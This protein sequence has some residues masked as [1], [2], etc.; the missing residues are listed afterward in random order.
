MKLIKLILL[1][2][3]FCATVT[4][5][6]ATPIDVTSF[7]AVGDNSTDNRVFIQNAINSAAAGDTVYF[8]PGLFNVSGT[9]YVPSNIRVQGTGS[10]VYNTQ[11]RLTPTQTALFEVVENGA[12]N[13][14]FKDLTLVANSNPNVYPRNSASETALIRTEGTTG[15]SFKA[16][17]GGM[18]NIVIENVRTTQ[19][20]YGIAATSATPGS[21]YPITDV[22]IRNYASDGNEYSLYTKTKGAGGWDVQNM[23]VYPMYDGQNGIFLERSGQMQFLQLSCAGVNTANTC[24]K[25]WNNGDTYFRQMHVE[26][27]RLGFCVGTNCIPNQSETPVENASRITVENSATGGEIN[28]A[29][30][31]VTINNRFWLDY[32]TNPPPSPYRFFGTGTNSTLTSCG[33]VW[34]SWN[35]STHRTNTTV[36]IPSWA[37]P[38]LTN[39]VSGCVN[40]YLTPVPI[41]KTGYEADN[42]RL[43]GEIDVTA[44]PFYA[45]PNDGLD[46]TTAFVNAI[47]AAN[48][49]RGKRVFVPAGTFDISSTL[50][51]SGDGQTVLGEAGSIIH[52]TKSNLSLFKVV[53]KAGYP[54]NGI[55]FRNL[56]LTSDTTSGTFGINFEN[57]DPAVVGAASDFQIQNV[58]FTGFEAGIAVRPVGGVLSNANPMFD[59]VSIKDADFSGNKTAILIR[60]GNASNWNMENIRVNIPNG[61]E[62]IRLDGAGHAS[63]RNLSC[64]SAGTGTACV[65]IQR[66]SGTTIENLSAS[67]VTNALFVPWENGWTQFPVTVRNSNLQAGVYIQGRI[68]LNSVNNVYP[69]KLR[70]FSTSK[71]VKFGGYLDGS[72][73]NDVSYGGLS[74][75]FS[76]GDIFKDTTTTF[77]QTTWIYLGTLSTPVT[78]CN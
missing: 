68:Y 52:L 22:K 43:N 1:S 71:D 56:T 31:L 49:T 16:G 30:N 10:T 65:I 66:Q 47:A 73:Y 59:S 4:I 38:G 37:F 9:I 35:P 18:S 63:L 67:G 75:V 39:P 76:C 55:T 21:D 46:D 28:R 7:G 3:M 77:F 36:T 41:F 13:I 69:A 20:T 19:F 25:L 5:A 2:V 70:K 60:S 11:I 42:E 45:I 29:T 61:E 58:D 57:Y 12:A 33:N 6:R 24:A 8:P 51:L 15:I 34:V 26:G 27:P 32:P 50:N 17:S 64:T 62:G 72:N 48:A 14:V 23:D 74:D 54:V 78:Y 40:S 53:N 44:P